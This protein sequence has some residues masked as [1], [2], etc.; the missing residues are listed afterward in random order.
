M[1]CEPGDVVTYALH[2][3]NDVIPMNPLIGK[4]IKL[5]FEQKLSVSIAVG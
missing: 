4:T 2:L 1:T 5:E 3:G